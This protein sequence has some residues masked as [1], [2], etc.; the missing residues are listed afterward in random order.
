MLHWVQT[1]GVDDV[2]AELN[3]YLLNSQT[4]IAQA[5]SCTSQTNLGQVQLSTNDLNQLQAW[6]TDFKPF[7][8]EVYRATT[9]RPLIAT[10]T[11]TGVGDVDASNSDITLV[12]NMAERLYNQITGG[13]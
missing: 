8:G 2:C 9:S 11:F 5:V 7:D 10:V 12:N 6:V 13:G 1:G 3:L 4:A